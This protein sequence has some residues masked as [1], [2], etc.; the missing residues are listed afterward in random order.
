MLLPEL[1]T[2]LLKVIQIM[3]DRRVSEAKSHLSQINQALTDLNHAETD[4]D[5]QNAAR[6]IA[7]SLAGKL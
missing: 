3:Q 5:Y 4:Q 1:L 7:L 6:T 2:L